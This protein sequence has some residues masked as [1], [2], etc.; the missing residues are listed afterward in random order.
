[1]GRARM[2]AK[3]RERRVAAISKKVSKEREGE[4]I[5]N[6]VITNIETKCQNCGFKA[7]YQFIRCPECNE[8][9]G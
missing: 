8:L 4:E 3:S 7:R 9:Q 6:K 1:M 2:Y 5:S